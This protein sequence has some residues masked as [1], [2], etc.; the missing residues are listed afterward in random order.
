MRHK[1]I[2][3]ILAAILICGA[4]TLSSCSDDDNPAQS[5][6]N[7][8]EKV[9]GKW[10]IDEKDGK[11]A[12]TNQK[13]VI[14][15]KSANKVSISLSYM[16][17]WHHHDLFDY[18]IDGNVITC[19]NQLDEHT[20]VNTIVKV[21]AIDA[22]K[23]DEDF[24][25]TISVDG[26]EQI[27][28]E[29][30]ETLKRIT[31]D[32]STAILGTWEGKVTS[33]D[34]A[35]TDGEL[36]RWEYKADGTYVYY[37]KENGE[38]KAGTDFR[39][40]YFVDGILL[41]TR[42]KNTADSDE[43]REWWEIESIKDGVMKWK[44]L[45]SREDGTTYTATFEMTKVQDIW[46][47]ATGTLYVNTNPGK[48]AYEGRRD[49]VSVVFS[50]AVTSIGDSAFY[51][52]HISVVDLPASVVSIG[53]EAFAGK[54]SSLEKV[55]IYATD[56]TFG[57][58]P[59]VQSILTNVYVPAESLDAYKASYPGYKSQVYAI[60]EVE[61][62]GNEIIWSEDLCEYIW[63]GIPYYHEDRIV[64]AHNT[65]GGIT[66]NF[67]ITDENSGFDIGCIS[68]VQGEKL[69]FTST[70]G[71]ISK[72]TILADYYED[73]DEEPGTP[74]AEGWTWD[75]AKRTFT[76]QGT[77][78]AAVEM[79]ASGEVDLENIQIRFTIE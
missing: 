71:N 64:A 1:K 44:A 43:L 19:A 35:H 49:I 74:V 42:W 26:V 78:S 58:H 77:P 29:S 60:P 67:A 73:E 18:T 28:M 63:V 59:F 79:I 40:D 39:S 45:R 13:L 12:L 53:S 11:P 2:L 8:T 10:M 54:E 72:I 5:D 76:W 27:K 68:L 75:A 23:M 30:K 50:D 15:F 41:C 14:D 3:L 52:C 17:F 38:W 20:F 65:Q 55:T 37:S 22:N 33:E 6:L 69:T 16:N 51:N 7:L 47:A 56:C 66:V 32:Y 31:D 24:S 21:N 4:V 61:Q 36:H 70:V 57:E 25:N 46:D 48:R 9:I 62:D 34:D